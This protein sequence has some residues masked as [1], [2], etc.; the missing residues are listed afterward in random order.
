M[1]LALVG[2]LSALAWLLARRGWRKT[3]RSLA[4]VGLG[5]LVASGTGL[6][7]TPLL[8]GLQEHVSVDVPMS[9]WTERSTIVVLGVGLAEGMRGGER[10][11]PVWG[12]GRLVRVAE[13]YRS[14]SASRED[15]RVV[16]SG[17][18]GRAGNREADAYG[19]ALIRMGVP[20]SALVYERESQN[21]WENARNTA[22]LL[23]PMGRSKT[24]LVTSALHVRRAMEYFSAFDLDTIAVASD[25]LE[26]ESSVYPTA[27]NV[28]M[29]DLALHEYIGLLRFSVY[30]ALSIN[31]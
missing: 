4:L 20:V 24:V 6:A 12:F 3:S 29:A 30:D 31:K 1:T 9:T 13:L 28:A 2:L 8:A 27:L 7:T 19:D 26:S 21:T 25:F 16:L 14:C 5:W 23:H 15:C 17:G 11:V 22:A 10:E 18:V